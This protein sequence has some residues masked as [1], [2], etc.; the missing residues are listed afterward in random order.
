VCGAR[1]CSWGFIETTPE[2]AARLRKLATRKHLPQPELVPYT[3]RDG[4]DG[5]I[6]QATP[7]V[8]LN[9]ANLCGIYKDRPQ[10]CRDF[11][12]TARDWCPLSRVLFAELLPYHQRPAPLDPEP[13]PKRRAPRPRQRLNPA[14]AL[15]PNA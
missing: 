14:A 4:S 6:M 5:F 13:E 1:C 11:P 12:D 3:A 9:K 2:E 7:C 8:F 10:H 15:D